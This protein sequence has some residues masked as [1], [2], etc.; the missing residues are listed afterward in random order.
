MGIIRWSA[1]LLLLGVCSA[2][3]AGEVCRGWVYGTESTENDFWCPKTRDGKGAQFCCGT[4]ELPY[5]CSSE[6]ERLDQRQCLSDGRPR[7]RKQPRGKPEGTG[8]VAEEMTTTDIV[9]LVL[10]L[11]SCFVCL[12]FCQI[13]PRLID[14]WHSGRAVR[15]ARRRL[16][17]SE[18]LFE[19][20][21]SPFRRPATDAPHSYG[22]CV[23]QASAGAEVHQGTPPL[24]SDPPSG[25]ESGVDRTSSG[26]QDP[27][28]PSLL[29]SASAPVV[30]HTDPAAPKQTN[31]PPGAL[32]VRTVSSPP[33]G[34]PSFDPF[35]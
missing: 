3:K 15:A 16:A 10:G 33:A 26:A 22:A 34:Q 9:V 5:C 8:A 25:R 35:L 11:V 14:V 20:F 17:Q 23:S 24:P 2:K 12:Y 4:C 29:R 32:R 18:D 28:G 6:K 30:Q 21:H 31:L 1:L 13:C 19:D 7:A 27:R